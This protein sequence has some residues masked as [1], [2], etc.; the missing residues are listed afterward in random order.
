[1]W[2][3]HP[4]VSIQAVILLDACVNNCGKKFHLEVASREFETEARKLLSKGHPKVV[5]K[6]KFALCKW[7]ENEFKSD[8]QLNF[9]VAIVNNL[10]NEGQEFPSLEPPKI[11]LPKEPNIVISDQEEEGIIKALASSMKDMEASSSRLSSLYPDL[12]QPTTS[13]VGDKNEKTAPNTQQ[14][15]PTTKETF[16]VGALYDFEAVGDNELTFKAG[17]VITFTDNRDENWWS[18]SSQCG[19]G[20]LPANF[21]TKD[22]NAPIEYM[23]SGKNVQFD[24]Q[25]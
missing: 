15:H 11:H 3:S 23:L 24:D 19:E 18:G 2:L 22:L 5:G 6:F 7:S 14:P 1:M 8:P 25:A 13:S 17:D 21:V 9:I 12:S 20:M 4:N 10:K 16:Q